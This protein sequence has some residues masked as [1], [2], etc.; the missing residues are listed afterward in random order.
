MGVSRAYRPPS[1]FEKFGDVRYTFDGVPLRIVTLARGNVDAETLLVRELGYLGQFLDNRLGVDMRIFEEN[2]GGRIKR[3]QYEAPKGTTL[4]PSKP[5]DFVNG[6]AMTIRGVEYEVKWRPWRDAQFILGQT[7]IDLDSSLKEDS[8]I[9]PK[10]ASTLNY[11]H[12]LPGGLDLSLMYSKSGQSR[13]VS[14]TQENVFPKSRTDLRLAWPVRF[15][16]T[17]GEL[18]AVVQNLGAP[19]RVLDPVF[20]FERRAFVTLQLEN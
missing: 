12:K 1:T 8:M 20:K 6:E 10:L 14:S 13:L 17:K 16:R 11:F 2:M 7:Y 18:A 15:G 4:L 19:Y 9:A 3:I 5:Y